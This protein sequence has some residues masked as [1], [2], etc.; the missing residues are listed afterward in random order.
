MT[1]YEQHLLGIIAELLSADM[2]RGRAEHN[3]KYLKGDNPLERR[4]NERAVRAT[5]E[6]YAKAVM[7][8]SQELIESG[9]KATA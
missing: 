1:R 7:A 5:A 3:L 9:D 6:R 2:A 4:S 8:A